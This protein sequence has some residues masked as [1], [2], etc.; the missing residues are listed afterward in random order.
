MT[1]ILLTTTV[2][3]QNKCA[4]L[5]VDP[6]DRINTY[7]KSVT[8]WLEKTTFKIVV[9]ENTG[10]SFPE[11]NYLNETYKDRFEIIH[12]KENELPEANYLYNNISKGASEIFAIE[13]AY[14]HSKWISKD[15]FLIKITGRFFIPNLESFLVTKDLNSYDGLTQQDTFRCQM[16]GVHISRFYD[17]FHPQLYNKNGEYD[18][19]V[20]RMY[21]ERMTNFTEEKI[22]R[23]PYF[24]IEPTKEGG[25]DKIFTII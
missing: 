16:V 11:W 19:H 22:L 23:C 2:Y 18:G 15:T 7:T 21:E 25:G 24:D 12:F 9:V 1:I 4:L 10:Y 14:L 20:E 5:Q 3:V 13:Y 17:I 8:Q 6:I